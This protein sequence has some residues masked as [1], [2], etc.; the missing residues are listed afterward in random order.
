VRLREGELLELVI[1]LALIGGL[2]VVAI[3]VLGVLALL[4]ILPPCGS[5]Q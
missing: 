2:A 4:G 5:G 3:I 1:Y